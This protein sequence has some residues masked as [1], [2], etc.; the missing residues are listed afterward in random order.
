MADG[1]TFLENKHDLNKIFQWLLMTHDKEL[2][3]KNELKNSSK[4][5]TGSHISSS[6][7]GLLLWGSVVASV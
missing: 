1:I 4:H 6:A 3:I 2:D 5:V 7:D